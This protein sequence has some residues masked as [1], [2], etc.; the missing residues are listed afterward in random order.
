MTRVQAACQLKLLYSN[1][2]AG[3]AAK[4][5]IMGRTEGATELS[6]C[7][8]DVNDPVVSGEWRLFVISSLFARACV[9]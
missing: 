5:V 8:F 3:M 9:S 4:T 1:G 2:V 6:T 7:R